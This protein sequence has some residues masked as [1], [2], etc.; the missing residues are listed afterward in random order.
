MCWPLSLSLARVGPSAPWAYYTLL[1]SCVGISLYVT[2]ETI[3][4]RYVT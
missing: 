3:A 4:K 2:D 1:E